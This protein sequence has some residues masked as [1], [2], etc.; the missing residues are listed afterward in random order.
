MK[1]GKDAPTW[2]WI[3]MIIALLMTN[4]PILNLINGY[5]KS[6]PLTMSWPTL[7]LWLQFWYLAMLGAIIYL[8]V[9]DPQWQAEPLEEV[10]E[11]FKN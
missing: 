1:K 11:E 9:K 6:V 5:A 8:A 7:W 10:V 2:F 4:P 3:F